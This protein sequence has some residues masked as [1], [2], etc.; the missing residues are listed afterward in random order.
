[1]GST[2]WAASE[3]LR[4]LEDLLW[5]VVAKERTGQKARLA[6]MI[7]T[8]VGNLRKGSKAV[9]L[10]DDRFKSFMDELYQ[11]H[12]AAI[13]QHDP[14]PTPQRWPRRCGPPSPTPRE[15]RRARHPESPWRASTIS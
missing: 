14:A 12:I 15:R 4:T 5:S 6:K 1:M 11:L 10:A 9:A 8:L 7:P 13:K 3:A 2:A